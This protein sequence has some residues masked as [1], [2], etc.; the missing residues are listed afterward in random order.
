MRQLVQRRR[1]THMHLIDTHCHLDLAEFDTD[2]EAVITQA[3]QSGVTAFVLPGIHR[4]EWPDLVALCRDDSALHFALGLH[5]VYLERH[6]DEHL[7]DLDGWIARERPLAVGEIGLD[8]QLR[9]LNRKRQ[10]TLLDA[11]L[12]IAENAGLPVLLHVRKAHDEVLQALHRHHLPGGICHAFNGSLQQ[13][14]R[15][16]DLGFKLGFGG[17]LTYE[18][19]TRLRA[20]AKALPD[21]ALVLETD[22][23]DM[24]VASHRYQR[25]SPEFLPE[26][27]DTLARLRN[28][29]TAEL[30]ALTTRNASEVL[31]LSH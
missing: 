2:R 15:Y 5:P 16:L 14:H 10:R 13:A 20:L 31:R 24:T 28:A 21:A 12:A 23:P 7:C 9:E 1:F 18:R 22:A 4:E 27:L 26:V 25:N 29:E 19:S 6:R 30:A 11:Q 8:F 17:M 3:K